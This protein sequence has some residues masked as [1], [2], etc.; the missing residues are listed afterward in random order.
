MTIGPRLPGDLPGAAPSG[1]PDARAALREHVRYPED[2]FS[3]QARVLSRFHVQDPLV[4][5]NQ[6]SFW[7]IPN[8]TLEQGT[9]ARARGHRWNPIT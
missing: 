5:Y 8:E 6:T 2:L 4:F 9:Q 1:G 7:D 3:V